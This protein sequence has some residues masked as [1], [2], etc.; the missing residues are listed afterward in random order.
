MKLVQR[1]HQHLTSLNEANKAKFATFLAALALDL[2][3]L[4]RKEAEAA[5]AEQASK[6]Q[7]PG[8]AAR[9]DAGLGQD[10]IPTPPDTPKVHGKDASKPVATPPGKEPGEPGGSE[11]K[12]G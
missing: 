3:K 9:L 11:K 5:A 2:A 1:A 10:A 12:P 4:D 8:Q 7:E 6:P